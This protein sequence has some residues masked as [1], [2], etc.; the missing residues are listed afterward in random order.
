MTQ[1]NTP[2][3]RL[4]GR[5]SGVPR[6]EQGQVFVW[7]I[8]SLQLLL[9]GV[10][11]F[12][13]DTGRVY[14][15]YQELLMSTNASAL[16]GGSGLPVQSTAVSNA[17]TYSGVSGEKNSALSGVTMVSGYPKV[18][19]IA[20]A[21]LPIPCATASGTYNV[22]QVAQQV[23][24]PMTLA[25]YFGAKSVTLTAL[26]TASASGSASTPYN[27]ALIID[28]TSSMGQSGSDS[29]TDPYT[30]TK[31]TTSE[32]CALVGA[33]VLLHNTAPCAG[34]LSTCP[35]GDT[36]AVD[37]ISLLTFPNGEAS[38]MQNDYTG[39]CTGPTVNTT[40]GYSYPDLS[41]STAFPGLS[42]TSSSTV[43]YGSNT[44]SSGTAV[45]GT[46]GPSTSTTTPSYQVTGFLSDFRTSDSSSTLNTSS[47]LVE[48]AGGSSGCQGLQ[49]PGGLGTFY[50]GAL[51]AA[52][53]LIM[54]QQT[55]RPGS[56]NAIVLL[57]DG[58][59]N[60]TLMAAGTL[61]YVAT[62]GTKTQ[63]GT[64]AATS[65][66]TYPS[67]KQQCQQAINV[68]K[69][70]TNSGTTIYAVAYGSETTSSSCS[71]DTGGLTPCSAMSQIASS[72]QTFFTDAPN[73]KSSG[74]TS[75]ENPETAL[76]QIFGAIAGDLTK[77]R[78]VPNS[79]FNA[80]TA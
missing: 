28:S 41:S 5:A 57:S 76:A 54:Y 72:A 23:T 9:F 40:A 43:T 60:A 69:S 6:R 59:A 74:C 49:T 65:G 38:T 68:A 42:N 8:L 53:E 39:K 45:A 70:I 66:S 31:Y 4:T 67:T 24:V 37:M 7:A 26:A 71:T 29:C 62:K 44:N 3:Q 51:V 15:S 22:I 63:L 46:Y 16:A 30:S 12:V 80:A 55:Q 25:K 78:L 18:K 79:I 50:A 75:S 58:A 10:A 56:Q 36:N 2:H 17:N 21:T 19:C 20:Y 11:G 14:L 73:G 13:I 35:T 32:G 47:N 61:E 64:V 52:Q 33:R 27:I 48:A 77:A 34:D 1:R